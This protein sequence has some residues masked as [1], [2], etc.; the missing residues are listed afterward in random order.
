MKNN[1]DYSEQNIYGE[2]HLGKPGS[3]GYNSYMEL[4]DREMENY[5][6]QAKGFWT[7]QATPIKPTGQ[8]FSVSIIPK[9]FE[10]KIREYPSLAPIKTEKRQSLQSKET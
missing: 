10:R 2:L 4:Y 6:T 8:S 7:I 3:I 5:E 9:V 1:E